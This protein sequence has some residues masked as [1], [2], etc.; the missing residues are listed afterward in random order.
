MTQHWLSTK[1]LSRCAVALSEQG[2]CVSDS[3]F[4]KPFCKTLFDD[5][6][7][8]KTQSP[9][10]KSGIGRKQELQK[11][12]E[13]RGDFTLWLDTSNSVQNMFLTC[14]EQ[15]RSVMNQQLFLNLTDA[16]FHYAFYPPNAGYQKH[17]DTFKTSDARTV[18]L[19]LYLNPDWNT[20]HR[21]QL[22]LYRE[23][24]DTEILTEV[25]PIFGRCAMFLSAVFPHEVKMTTAERFSVTGWLKKPSG[26]VF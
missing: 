22:T 20:S 14:I 5:L 11:N 23:N 24:N 8:Q 25:E 21:G 2:F 19:I 7:I 12:S 15:F 26:T 3:L 13:I 10:K 4:S 18:S 1:E 16:E 17:K 9:F 6:I